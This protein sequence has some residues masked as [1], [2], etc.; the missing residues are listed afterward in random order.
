MVICSILF[1]SILRCSVKTR[2]T[3]FD[4]WGRSLHPS[5]GTTNCMA[6]QSCFT[7]VR[8]MK[9]S[10]CSSLGRNRFA[11]QQRCV[12]FI[13]AAEA[14]V[15]EHVGSVGTIFLVNHDPKVGWNMKNMK[16]P[17]AVGRPLLPS[18]SSEPRENQEIA[19]NDQ[20]KGAAGLAYHI[21]HIGPAILFHHIP[22]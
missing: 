22:P 21:S 18:F 8:Q 3:Q 12:F 9:W 16:R 19:Q 15:A 10:S 1:H 4:P 17:T 6:L 14:F 7:A 5:W 20:Q 2:I 13:R 11:T